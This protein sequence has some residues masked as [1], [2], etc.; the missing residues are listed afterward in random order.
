M[1]YPTEVSEQ[2]SPHMRSSKRRDVTNEG[3]YSEVYGSEYDAHNLYNEDE[4][5]VEFIGV[6]SPPDFLRVAC[7]LPT[8]KYTSPTSATQATT[9]SSLP[10]NASTTTSL[11][12]EIKSLRVK[13]YK[14]RTRVSNKVRMFKGCVKNK[15]REIEILDE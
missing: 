15:E 12:K 14:A 2:G 13:Y 3:V 5:D 7:L 4:D 8:P 10:N 6:N 9:H 11:L 1:G